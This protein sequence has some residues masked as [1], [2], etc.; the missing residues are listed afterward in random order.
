M[1]DDDLG[2]RR[3][4]FGHPC[5]LPVFRIGRIGII[6]AAFHERLDVMAQVE[7]LPIVIL[8]ARHEID[9]ARRVPN[10]VESHVLD[11]GRQIVPSDSIVARRRMSRVSIQA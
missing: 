1:L 3:S 9:Q 6:M 5:L 8:R 2:H 11:F 7:I 10:P 4:S